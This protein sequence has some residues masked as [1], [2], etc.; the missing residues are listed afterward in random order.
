M[1]TPREIILAKHQSATPRLDRVRAGVLQ[2]L[3][4]DRN[5]SLLEQLRQLLGE[6]LFAKPQRWAALGSLWILISWFKIATPEAGGVTPGEHLRPPS[7]VAEL[8]KQRA[9][10]VELAGLS[11]PAAALPPKN[12]APRPRSARLAEFRQT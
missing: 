10:F 3:R 8:R 11:Q 9:F 12:D 4:C 5:V 7:E 2:T 1:K 6:L